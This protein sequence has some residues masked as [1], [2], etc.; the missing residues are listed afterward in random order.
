MASGLAHTYIPSLMRS[1]VVASLVVFHSGCDIPQTTDLDEATTV[2]NSSRPKQYNQ[3]ERIVRDS[4][5][6][7]EEARAFGSLRFGMSAADARRARAGSSE[8]YAKTTIG[9]YQYDVKEYYGRFDHLYH[10]DLTGPKVFASDLDESNLYVRNLV[11]HLESKF[12]KC[13]R[14]WTQFECPIDPPNQWVYAWSVGRKRIWVSL[15]PDCV[16]GMQFPK[17]RIFDDSLFNAHLV[18]ERVRDS[19]KMYQESNTF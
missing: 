17:A 11:Y 10:I 9:D 4:L 8:S 1:L 16:S 7:E 12:G 14:S 15:W 3:R 13:N 5:L 2:E 6:H 19:L 18:D